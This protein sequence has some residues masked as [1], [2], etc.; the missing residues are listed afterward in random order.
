MPEENEVMNVPASRLEMVVP[1]SVLRPSG[2]FCHC[3]SCVDSRRRE[4]LENVTNPPTRIV[5]ENT[6]SA[7]IQSDE[8]MDNSL[9]VPCD[10]CSAECDPNED[11]MRDV[12]SERWC[13]NCADIYSFVCSD[14]DERVPNRRAY[15]LANGGVVCS[16][17]NSD[18]YFV[19]NDCDRRLHNDDYG[20]NGRC[21]RCEDERDSESNIIQSYSAKPDCS[22]IGTGPH[23]LGVELEVETPNGNRVQRAREV[24]QRLGTFAIVKEDGSLPDEG[25]FEICTSPASLDEQRARWSE[26][27]DN[28]PR[29]LSSYNTDSCGLHVHCSRAPLSEL[30]IAKIVCFVNAEHNRPFVKLIAARDS[31]QWAKFKLKN[32]ETAATDCS[33]RYEAVNLQNSATIEFRI[34]KGT[35]KK[36]SLFKALEFCDALVA[37]CSSRRSVERCMMR[38]EFISYVRTKKERWPHLAAFIDAKWHGLA[39]DAAKAFGYTPAEH[40]AAAGETSNEGEE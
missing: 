18:N 36:E 40:R 6:F 39:T 4:W 7:T 34:F 14:C 11:T 35:L 28:R 32:I 33:E 13:E 20:S 16:A 15:S 3:E 27:L 22:P 29:G 26:L 30:T 12:A 25:G 8:E 17:C 9:L 1:E 31:A 23:W 19:C 37:Y 24:L 38:S 5:T 21:E 2:N 10:R